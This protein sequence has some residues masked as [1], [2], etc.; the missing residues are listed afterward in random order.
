MRSVVAVVPIH[1][2]DMRW[3]MVV[4]VGW[5]LDYLEEGRR[6]RLEEVGKMSGE[7]R[8]ML[9]QNDGL[10]WINSTECTKRRDRNTKCISSGV[11][12]TWFVDCRLVDW[13]AGYDSCQVSARFSTDIRHP[14]VCNMPGMIG[15]L[16]WNH[17]LLGVTLDNRSKIP[18]HCCRFCC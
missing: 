15:W 13:L 10:I 14:S 11:L 17:H 12:V 8:I 5:R 7:L 18:W 6:L 3:T 1:V 9:Q 2:Y 4:V 16:F